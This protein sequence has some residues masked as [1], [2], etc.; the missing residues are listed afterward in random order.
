[1]KALLYHQYG[2]PD[3]VKMAEV[4]KPIA[5]DNEVL[6]R[7]HATT[8]TTADW[9][10]RSLKLPDG[11]GIL[12]RLV[13]GILKPRKPILGSELAGV[14]EATGK[15]VTK[16]KVGDAVVAFTG[17][18]FGCH[19]EYRTIPEQGLIVK[20]PANLSFERAAALSFGG[21]TALDFLRNKGGI[22]A[23]DKVLIVGASGGVGSAAV[24]LAKHFGAIVT[25]VC[26]TANLQTMHLIGATKTIDYTKEDFTKNGETY[27]IILDVTGTVSYARC[28]NS[29]K[30]AGRLLLVLASFGQTLGFDRSPKGSDKKVITGVAAER[31]SDLK[32]LAQLAETEEFTPVIDQIY[33]F[34]KAVEAHARVDTGHKKGNVIISLVSDQL[35]EST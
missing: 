12:G 32:F 4:E 34:D 28:E 19:A 26:S 3:V 24:Q 33:P 5:K 25:A 6:I 11:F 15:D 7:I 8:I 27:D 35:E 21:T 17:A 14:I 23:G 22:R 2:A 18:D 1:M 16:F 10:A 20:K 31:T 29:L 9:R 30:P 13:F